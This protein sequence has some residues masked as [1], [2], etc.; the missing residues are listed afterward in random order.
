MNKLFVVA[1]LRILGV[2]GLR[3]I[4]AGTA[5][6]ECPEHEAVDPKT[7][8]K[9][10]GFGDNVYFTPNKSGMNRCEV[11]SGVRIPLST[12]LN[13]GYLAGEA[14]SFMDYD[15]FRLF[16]FGDPLMLEDR[17][18][19]SYPRRVHGTGVEPGSEVVGMLKVPLS[20]SIL[21]GARNTVVVNRILV[22]KEFPVPLHITVKHMRNLSIFDVDRRT[23][24]P[25]Q[26]E[27]FAPKYQSHSF[28]TNA[29]VYCMAYFG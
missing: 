11:L 29:P 8:G 10:I 12:D 16:L 26:K 7:N 2:H 19:A 6:D 9:G 15:F 24:T 21:K 18:R 20:I 17:S 3:V 25:F 27:F 22:V 13:A 23:A 28:W 4:G 14:W 1:S 5:S